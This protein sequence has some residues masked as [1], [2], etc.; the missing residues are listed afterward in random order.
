MKNFTTIS[1]VVLLIITLSTTV[2]AGDNSTKKYEASQNTISS[3]IE[4]LKS[5]NAGL[6][7]SCAYLLGELNVTEGVIPLMRLLKNDE[8]EQVRICAALAL[9]KIGTPISIFAVK[10]AIRFD[11]SKRVNKLAAKF[12]YDYLRSNQ[13][14]DVKG[15]EKRYAVID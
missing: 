9:Y 2:F 12:Y 15:K 11:E 13:R 10:Q 7:T 4:G 8:C 3:L 14:A 6:K 5:D 1:T